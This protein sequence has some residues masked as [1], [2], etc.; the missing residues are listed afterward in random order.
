MVANSTL[1]LSMETDSFLDCRSD[2]GNFEDCAEVLPE[3]EVWEVPSPEW[4]SLAEAVEAAPEG[5]HIVVLAGHVELLTTPLVI[6]RTLYIEGP[7]AREG[8]A[9]F[10]GEDGIVIAAMHGDQSVVLR[11]L[12]LNI[13]HAPAIVIAGGCSVERCRI[14]AAGVG[15]EVA[16]HIGSI[17][18]I[19]RS[20]VR[21][22]RVGLSLAGGTVSLEHSRIEYCSCGLS[23]TGLEMS[24][25]STDILSSLAGAEFCNNG[26]ADLLLRGWSVRDASGVSEAQP[27]TEVVVNSWPREPCKILTKTES[28]PAIL[29]FKD[30]TVSATFTSETDINE[31]LLMG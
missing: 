21:G 8:V 19:T 29:Y 1:D 16:A 20:L 28:R 6:D 5:T 10:I 30:G 13:T 27:G 17:V 18:N 31:Q 2:A 4:G 3:V 26:D 11:R 15:I 14:E 24:E 12:S 22:C 9:R 23:V 7:D 25:S